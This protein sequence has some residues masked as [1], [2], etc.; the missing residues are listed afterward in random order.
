MKSNILNLDDLTYIIR[1]LVVDIF[2]E[3]NV[4]P[5]LLRSW[6]EN[7]SFKFKLAVVQSVERTVLMEVESDDQSYHLLLPVALIC[8]CKSY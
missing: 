5:Q 7:N 6:S 3:K 2:P 4:V 8:T 1:L